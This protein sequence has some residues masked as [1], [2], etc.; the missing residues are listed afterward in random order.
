MIDFDVFLKWAEE[1]FDL[2]SVSGGEI[3]IN[4]VFSDDTKQHLW[5]N[6]AKNAYHCWKSDESGNLFELVAKVS[7]CNIQEAKTVLNN[8]NELRKLEERL[9]RFFSEKEKVETKSNIV[10]PKNTFLISKMVGYLRKK[11][12][13]YV[14]SRCLDLGNLHFCVY[15]KYANRIIIPYYDSKGSLVYWNA[16]DVTGRS[17]VKYLGPDKEI[18][19]GKGDVIFTENWDVDKI[20]LAEG[21]FDAMSLTKCGFNGAACGGKNLTDKQVEIARPYKVCLCFDADKSGA[22]A[23]NKVGDKLIN[24]G[25]EVTYVR[26]PV[27]IKDWNKMLIEAG[28]NVVNLFIKS[29]E[30]PFTGWTSSRLR[31]NF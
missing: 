25:I 14:K 9:E 10:F 24:N 18:G 6:P 28:K 13:E 29:Q 26:P 23:L 4:S 16:R 22:S 19:V 30:K 5:C 20:Y 31:N 11:T 21:E 2:V 7:K 27:D 1:H 3:K 8:D 12:E 17:K 15:G